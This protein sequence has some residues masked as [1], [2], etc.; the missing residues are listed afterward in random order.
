MSEVLDDRVPEPFDVRRGPGDQVAIA[1]DPVPPHEAA[2]VGVI[3]DRLGRFPDVGY[4]HEI[5]DRVTT[6]GRRTDVDS[7]AS[8]QDDIKRLSAQDV[9]LPSCTDGLLGLKYLLVYLLT[10]N[11]CCGAASSCVADCQQ[12]MRATPAGAPPPLPLDIR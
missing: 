9:P 7:L 6:I 5:S 11:Y 1:G 8:R 4:R 10:N 3:D 2:D 12:S